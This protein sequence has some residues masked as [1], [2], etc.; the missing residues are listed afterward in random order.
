MTP[1][2]IIIAGGGIGGL[3][4]AA[5][6]LQ[7]GLD[8]EVLEQSPSLG[9]VGAG[10]QV[11]ANAARVYQHLGLLDAL[12]D[13]GVRPEAYRFRLFDSGE[14]LQTIPLGAGYV[15]QH[16]VPYITVHRADVH[17]LL[18]DRV[19][20]LK[21]DAIRLNAGVV[22]FEESPDGVSVL[23]HD[24]S[25]VEGDVLIGCDGI[26]SVVRTQIVGLAPAH[27]TG[28]ASWRVLV[29]MDDL[30]PEH[31]Q[32]TVDIWVGPGRHAVTYPLRRG[33]LLN[34]VGCVEQREWDQ[35][36]WVTSS[37]WTE[38]CE[39][40]AGWHA[41]IG[42]IIA[43]ADRQACYRWAM[44]DRA[45]ISNWSTAR[46]TLLGDAAHPTLPYMAQGAAMAVEDALVLTRALQQR[47]DAAE[48]LD[49]Y[50]RARLERTARIVRESAANRQLFHM[51]SEEALR[52]AFALRDMNKERNQW[53]FSYDP[54]NVELV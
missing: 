18:V 45:P 15:A 3:T 8:V 30:P 4:A 21:P 7:A 41:A 10:I 51:P 42:A 38:L 11:S 35:E 1:Q 13:V 23:L 39:D 20:A 32:D 36:S 52:Q 53:L 49:L 34:L 26:K 47:Q 33:S 28:D 50:Q 31:Q 16:G 46:A 6:L 44:N 5:C 27:F 24:G 29:K 54:A 40:F 22:S 19:R 17:A 43:A 14:V 12:A 48:A 37:P 2:K 9:E 25:R